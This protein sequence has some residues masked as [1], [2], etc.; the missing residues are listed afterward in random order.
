MPLNVK[1][2]GRPS[3]TECDRGESDA[4]GRKKVV[5]LIRRLFGRACECGLSGEFVLRR[6]PC[7]LAEIRGMRQRG[8]VG[9]CG[10]HPIGIMILRLIVEH[11][12]TAF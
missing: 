11:D 1:V 9:I 2:C 4:P 12:C 8:P 10:Y 3:R 7:A 6:F 5:A